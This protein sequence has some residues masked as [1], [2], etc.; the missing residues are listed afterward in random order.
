MLR[1]G[2]LRSLGGAVL[3]LAF[4]AFS[5]RANEHAHV[6][7]FVAGLCG[8]ALLPRQPLRLWVQVLAAAVSVGFVWGAWWL[9]LRP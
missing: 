4:T 1:R 7:G 6:G 2:L 3:L 9:A 8:G 5:A